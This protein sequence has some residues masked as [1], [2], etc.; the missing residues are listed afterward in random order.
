MC[1]LHHSI[2]TSCLFAF[3]RSDGILKMGPGFMIKM[4]KFHL[5]WIGNFHLADHSHWKIWHTENWISISKHALIW[6]IYEYTCN[7]CARIYK[8]GHLSYDVAVFQWITSC[9]KNRMTTRVITLL[10]EYATSLTTSVT[11][12]L[13]FIGHMSTF[14]GDKIVFKKSYDKTNLTLV[15]ISYEI[16]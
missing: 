5:S 10:R 4:R 9:H 8:Q 3:F 12:M 11:T 16:Y 13:I 7:S 1:C 6:W 15:V 14:R 2:A